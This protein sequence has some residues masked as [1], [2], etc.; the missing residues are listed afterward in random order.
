MKQKHLVEAHRTAVHWHDF[1]LEEILIG[2]GKCKSWFNTCNSDPQGRHQEYMGFLIHSQ[3]NTKYP[4]H[5]DHVLKTSLYIYIYTYI[6]IYMCTRVCVCVCVECVCLSKMLNSCV[7]SWQLRRT[8]YDHRETPLVSLLIPF[9]GAWGDQGSGL[10]RNVE[11]GD[12][13]IFLQCSSS[14]VPRSN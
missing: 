14:A 5:A 6:Y 10:D 13:L 3:K 4:G 7:Q 2:S 8:I 9:R 11:E 1:T 12:S